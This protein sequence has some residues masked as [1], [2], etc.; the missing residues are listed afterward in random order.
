VVRVVGGDG[1]GD[2]QRVAER[3]G[4]E[5]ALL[6]AQQHALPED[7]KA[8]QLRGG[9]GDPTLAQRPHVLNGLEADARLV[10]HHVP[11][12]QCLTRS[13]REGGLGGGVVA[14]FVFGRD[15]VTVISSSAI[16]MS[17]T[18]LCRAASRSTM[19]AA[20]CGYLATYAS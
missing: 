20:L 17:T 14:V 10:E 13:H 2:R 9:N 5:D 16:G 6:A 15:L 3:G 11:R 7:G 19:A 12:N 8:A 1:R 4:L 18:S